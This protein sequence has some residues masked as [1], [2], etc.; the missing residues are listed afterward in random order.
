VRRHRTPLLGL[1][2]TLTLAVTTSAQSLHGKLSGIVVDPQG[3][4]QMGATVTVLPEADLPTQV[5][6]VVTNDRGLFS[7]A[8][9][10]PG[11]YTVRVTLAGFLPAIERHIRI[12]ADLTTLLKIQLNSVFSSIERL[13]ERPTVPIDPDEWAWILR[14]SAATRP[15]LRLA[16]GELVVAM[17]SA[18][19]ETVPQ[20][21]PHGRLELTRGARRAGSPSNVVDAPG[22]AFAYQQSLGHTGRLLLAGQAS[23]EHSMAAGFATVWMPQGERGE[24]PETTLVLRQ[25]DLGGR[26]RFR[27]VRAA[28]RSEL[29]LGERLSLRYGA[30]FLLVGMDDSAT[31]LRP[32]TELVYDP[33]RNWR[34]ALIF[35]ARPWAGAGHKTNGLEWAL[36]QLDAFPAVMLRNGRAVVEGGQHA[37]L[38]VEHRIGPNSSLVAS[39]FRDRA[40]HTAVFGRG[41]TSDPDFLQDNF[42]AAFVYDGGPLAGWGTRLALRHRF[43]EEAEA[44]VIYAWAG[45][46]SP[47]EALVG[48]ELRDSFVPR[49]HH[50]LAVRLS[51]RVEGTGTQLSASYK[52]IGG[53][54][55]TRSDAYGEVV[56]QVEPFLNLTVRQP[57]PFTGGRFEALADFRNLLAEGYVSITTPDGRVLLIPALR[58]FRTGVSFQF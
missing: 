48:G 25:A 38:V 46:L 18:S 41:R 58:T 13:R 24:G 12:E 15:V 53:V 14:T 16:D 4:P 3:M 57:V 50:S 20:P 26:L 21:R 36:E 49:H 55:L 40:R 27:G 42:S 6:T 54:A 5:L 44:T 11:L 8:S 1:L 45:A 10:R 29:A 51:T 17:T 56:H 31:S 43:G 33:G 28:H 32:F 39:V 23:F 47:A 7:A 19:A 9:L 2:A 34:A 37:E 22:T 52:W 35:A 30:E